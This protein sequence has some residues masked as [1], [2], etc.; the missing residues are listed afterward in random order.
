MENQESVMQEAQDML[1]SSQAMTSSM[2]HTSSGNAFSPK[3]SIKLQENNFVL[4]NQQVEH[5]V[6]SHNLHKIVGN[7]Q[8]PSVFKTNI[9]R[10]SNIDL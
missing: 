7:P 5:V 4:W 9:E 2:V 1:K 8:I 6:L 3:L 10:L